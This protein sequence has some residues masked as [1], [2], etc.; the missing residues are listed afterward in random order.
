MVARGFRWN[1]FADV[2]SSMPTEKKYEAQVGYSRNV[3][4]WFTNVTGGSF[5][6]ILFL[7]PI[8]ISG[9][10]FLSGVPPA[11][12]DKFGPETER[13]SRE[14]YAQMEWEGMRVKVD[15]HQFHHLRFAG[16]IVLIKP[17]IEQA[18]PMLAE[19]DNAEWEEKNYD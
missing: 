1:P 12:D 17:N 19:F 2:I 6:S 9:I 15:C 5:V 16:Y 10:M 4:I 14:R 3:G 18:E 11:I 7:Q 8:N 13:R